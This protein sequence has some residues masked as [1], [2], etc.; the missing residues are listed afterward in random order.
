MK[1]E[2]V[3]KSPVITV[4][5]GDTLSDVA[6]VLSENRISGAPVVNDEGTLVGIIS[7]EDLIEKS[8][9]LNVRVSYDI[10]GWVSPQTSVEHMA[11][12]TQGLCTL[13]DMTVREIMTSRVLTVSPGDSLE[14]AAKLMAKRDIN[15]LPV[16]DGSELVGIISRADLVWAMV[17][18]CEVK[19]GIFDQ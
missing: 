15:R 18:L 16:L 13:G 17:H 11:R 8:Q 4:K 1:V 12:F 3:M 19:P 10:F 6:S 5:P 7:E 2:D 14:E 9:A